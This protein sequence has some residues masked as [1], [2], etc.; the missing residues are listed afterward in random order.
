MTSY[1]RYVEPFNE[2]IL[3]PKIVNPS[4]PTF[5]VFPLLFQLEAPFY[6]AF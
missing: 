5:S 1:R 3:M 6:S 4:S 2:E